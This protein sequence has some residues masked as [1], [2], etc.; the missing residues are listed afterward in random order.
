MGIQAGR[1]PGRNA[2]QG[3]GSGPQPITRHPLF[4]VL[5]ALWFGALF[6][7]GSLAVRI[8]L[9]ESLVLKL[10]VDQ[11]LS[12]AAPPLGMKARML[13]ALA[14]AVSGAVL[15]LWLGR[16][17]RDGGKANTARVSGAGPTG[18]AASLKR[19][20]GR[21]EPAP[22]GRR[23][24]LSVAEERTDSWPG[25]LAPLP[26]DR[27]QVLS[28]SDYDY[29]AP[30]PDAVEVAESAPEPALAPEAGEDPSPLDL[31]HFVAHEGEQATPRPFDAPVAEA[32]TES[33]R[34]FAAP[35]P[36]QAPAVQAPV[37]ATPASAPVAAAEG[38]REGGM[39]HLDLVNQLAEAMK[40][41]RERLAA[42]R[43]AEPVEEPC[44]DV[45][46]A[47]EAAPAFPTPAFEPV[48]FEPVAFEPVGT[49][50][51]E[52]AVDVPAQEPAPTASAPLPRLGQP[53]AP[54][55]PVATPVPQ[56]PAA[57]RPVAFDEEDEADLDISHVPARSI[58]LSPVDPAPQDAGDE[59]VEEEAGV[60]TDEALE[61]GYSSLLDLSRP[62]QPRQSFIR[63]ED[64]QA[65]MA[66]SEPEPV[67][68]FPGQAPRPFDAP[69]AVQVPEAA[70]A[71]AV[72]EP[73][74]DAPA[75][76]APRP[77][78]APAP[79]SIP[80]VLA[81]REETERALRTALA[82]LQRMSGAA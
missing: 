68:I 4:P 57:L 6:G 23:R 82:T 53:P 13:I 59:P 65:A 2:G 76:E 26:G 52:A 31:D 66:A 16:R 49:M 73:Q 44:A 47:A 36:E 11:V 15:G 45:A 39:T 35:L 10:R 27:P 3:K 9:I 51:E 33:L 43:A 21:E 58:S 28:A 30:L 75:A 1:N 29:I 8:G 22:V 61:D 32:A 71:P 60:T 34:P 17:L 56:M 19:V 50:P 55:A 69:A 18:L 20:V 63:I 5:V 80:A 67:V 74:A 78:A 24:A 7:L 40:A 48:A 81:D 25:D 64:P 77:F 41:R 72:P 62:A 37:P 79:A 46:P 12:F 38:C 14:M 42:A 70:P 54:E